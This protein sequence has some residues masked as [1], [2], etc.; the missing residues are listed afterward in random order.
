MTMMLKDFVEL[1]EF[2][3]RDISIEN[4]KKFCFWT[5]H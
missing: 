3:Q 2:Y 1:Q 5:L 4:K